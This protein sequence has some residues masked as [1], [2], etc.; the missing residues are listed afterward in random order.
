MMKLVSRTRRNRMGIGSLCSFE[1]V[2]PDS[3]NQQSVMSVSRMS[4]KKMDIGNM[5]SLH[6]C[7]QHRCLSESCLPT[8]LSS[9]SS[10]K[11]GSASCPLTASRR[12]PKHN[13][14]PIFCRSCMCNTH[15]ISSSSSSSRSSYSSGSIG[16]WRRSCNDFIVPCRNF[17]TNS[18]YLFIMLVQISR[19]P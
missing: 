5:S 18:G 8:D 1:L 19:S 10:Y 3:S 2:R 7:T 16:S 17:S 13:H 9:S 4:G 12:S 14:S 15:Q 11:T 6:S